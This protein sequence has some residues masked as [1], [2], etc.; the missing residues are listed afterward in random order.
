[1]KYVLVSIERDSEETPHVMMKRPSVKKCAVKIERQKE[2]SISPFE[3]TNWNHMP[4]EI[5]SDILM[6]VGLASPNDLRKCR[7]VCKN[8]NWV[9]SEMTKH[10]VDLLKRNEAEI[11]RLMWD[12]SHWLPSCEEIS[13]AKSLVISGHLLKILLQN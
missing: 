9:I 10:Q 2:D 11:V 3:H 7:Q 13:Q 5:L 1:M 8:W 12:Q 6:K 4:S